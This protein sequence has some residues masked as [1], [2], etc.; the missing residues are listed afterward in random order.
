M[1]YSDF[2]IINTDRGKADREIRG[3]VDGYDNAKG[4]FFLQ[5]RQ[6]RRRKRQ[7]KEELFSLELLAQVS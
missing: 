1:F 6:Q 7:T 4:F 2:Y 3:S 5:R